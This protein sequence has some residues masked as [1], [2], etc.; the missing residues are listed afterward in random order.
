MYGAPA[1]AGRQP[2]GAGWRRHVVTAAGPAGVARCPAAAARL[3]CVARCEA[4]LT[5]FKSHAYKYYSLLGS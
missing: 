4:Q 3:G 2:R 5:C 1:Q